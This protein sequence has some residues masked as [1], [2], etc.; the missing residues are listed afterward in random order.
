MTRRPP[1]GRA[2]FG[3]FVAITTRWMDNDAYGHVNNVVYYSFFDTAVNR[4]LIDRGV[5]HIDTSPV[6]GLVVETA[7]RY[8]QPLRYPDDVEVGIR[9]AHLG[10]SSVRYE[11]GIFRPGEGLASADGHF[12]HVYVDR[13]TRKPVP[14]PDD[15]RAVL[16]EL[17]TEE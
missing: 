13:D 7:C 12:I 15:L 16:E 3:H 9:V 2:G 6:I 8:H 1:P 14:L 11:L 10:T 4:Y 5:L 17:R